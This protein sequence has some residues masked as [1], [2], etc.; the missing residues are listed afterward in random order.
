MIYLN[1]KARENILTGVN[2]LADAVKVT[3]GPKGKNVV[4]FDYEGKAYLTKDGV[5]VA[6]KVSSPHPKI[7]AGIQILREA[8]AKTAE[9]AGDG[10]TTSTILAQYLCNAGIELMR[11]GENPSDIRRGMEGALQLIVKELNNLSEKIKGN[12]SKIKNVATV[13]SNNDPFIGDIVAKAFI[14]CGKNGVVTIE[15]SPTAT[16]YLDHIGGTQINSGA[17]SQEF[18]TDYK[19]LEAKYDN[20]YVL[21]VNN[22]INSFNEVI[23]VI[24]KV[25]ATQQALVIIAND[26]GDNAIR[27]FLRNNYQGFTKILPIKTAFSSSNRME[28]FKDMRAVTGADICN[29]IKEITFEGLGNSKKVIAS[30]TSSTF[31]LPDD[32]EVKLLLGNRVDIINGQIEEAKKLNPDLVESLQKRLAKLFGLVSVIYVGG[33]TE[34]EAK[35]RYDRVEDAVCAVRASLKEGICA[36]GGFTYLEIQKKLKGTKSKYQKGFNI[37]VDSLS[38]PF[39]WL[40]INAGLN[41]KTVR[42]LLNKPINIGKGYNFLTDK[43]ENLKEAG[44]IDPTRVLRVALENAVSVASLLISTDCIVSNEN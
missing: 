15:T 8:T 25:A 35:E 2:L 40:C 44:V 39:G 32:D 12:S 37:V 38:S 17:F 3:L 18:F 27:G 24:K 31:V 28:F 26:F 22:S 4:L 5:S 42:S 14:N 6:K 41:I 36:G 7:D 43:V 20:P 1:E 9:L 33:T 34:V 16:T 23:D 19:K 10:T 11:R 30:S 29:S 13:S 21:L